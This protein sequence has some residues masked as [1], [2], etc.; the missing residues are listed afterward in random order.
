MTIAIL[1]VLAL[2][3]SL[4]VGSAV[5]GA[6]ATLDPGDPE[7]TTEMLMQA[8][9]R[10]RWMQMGLKCDPCERVR[11]LDPPPYDWAEEIQ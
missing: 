3:V 6:I 4:V 1:I 2:V 7:Y 9:R 5:G 8:V 10:E 11:L